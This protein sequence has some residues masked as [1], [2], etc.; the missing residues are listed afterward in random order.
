M[1]STVGLTEFRSTMGS[2]YTCYLVNLFPYLH[3]YIFP[4][5]FLRNLGKE[6]SPESPSVWRGRILS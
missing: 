4:V 6:E 3:A 5:Q 1:E 2:R